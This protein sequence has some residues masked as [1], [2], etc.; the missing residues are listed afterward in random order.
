TPS[1]PPPNDPPLAIFSP[2][3][4]TGNAPLEVTFDATASSDPDG[5]VVAWNWDFGGTGTASGQVVSNTFPA[6][7]HVVTLTVV[8]DKGKISSS[9]TTITSLGPPPAPTGLTKTGSGCCNTYGDFA[10][11][12]V[13]G[14]TQ[15]QIEM[16]GYFG[17]GCVTDHSATI[18]GPAST[19][20]VQAFGL[21]LGSK[22]D[23]RIRAFANGFWGP[24]SPEVRITL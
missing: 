24:W 2:S 9:N 12:E 17:G 15:Y 16:D 11:N 5:T 13:A 3:V 20:R 7:S 10:W 21:C 4:S 1:G 22:Y 18:A 14:A 19:G 6:G 23:V 8:D